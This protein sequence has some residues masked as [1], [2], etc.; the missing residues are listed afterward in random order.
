MLA[1]DPDV[2]S[3]LE[4]M[5]AH[6][7]AITDYPDSDGSAKLSTIDSR[8]TSILN[9]LQSID[10][11]PDSDGLIKLN[12]ILTTLQ[13]S[14]DYPDLTAHTKLDTINTSINTTSSTIDAT[15]NAIKTDIDTNVQ[16][17]QSLD[18][19]NTKT[20]T[21][22]NASPGSPWVGV[23]KQTRDLG[24]VRLLTT[25]VASDPSVSGTFTFEFSETGSE[26]PLGIAP[27]SAQRAISSFDSIRDFDLL[28]AGAYYRVAFEPDAH[29]GGNSVTITT[30]LRN[31]NDGAFARL[32]D[33]QIEEQN[34]AMG[35]TFAYLKAFGLD[36]LSETVRLGGLDPDNST[37]DN[38]ASDGTFV[39]QWR[40]TGPYQSALAFVLSDQPLAAADVAYSPD[41]VNDR[42]GLLSAIDFL[43]S[44]TVFPDILG[45]GGDL[46]VYLTVITTFV[47]RY[48]RL[49][50]TNSSTATTIFEAD[51][52]LYDQGFPGSFGGLNDDLST[53][54]TALLTRAVLAG[55]VLDQDGNVTDD[56]ANVTLT[57]N[58]SLKVA[59]PAEV[60][61]QATD[62]TNGAIPSGSLPVI[63]QVLNT[64]PNVIDTGWLPT[65]GYQGNNLLNVLADAQLTTYIMNASDSDGNNMFGDQTP[66]FTAN[67]GFPATLGAQFFDNYF[68]L[69]FVN[70]S[71]STLTD[72]SIRDVALPTPAAGVLAS[73]DS[74][75]FGFY[76][77]QI[78]RSVI[79]GKAP[80]GSYVNVGT[81]ESGRITVTSGSEFAR[82]L[83]R[84]VEDADELR[85][86]VEPSSTE[87]YI[88]SALDGTATS[89]TDWN[90]IQISLS[91]TRNPNRIRFRQNVAWDNRTAGW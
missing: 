49:E 1:N 20:I 45:P 8:L 16:L 64:E 52:W 80:S 54:S 82:L 5:L 83:A 51:L 63:D 55:N 14:N 31:Q 28:N 67:G 10:D 91:G 68:R 39:G 73:I 70:A 22:V 43:D 71:G 69:V 23:W 65:R 76:P 18:A 62:E 32:S 86:D 24:V 9:H 42:T 30:T 59:S 35:Q 4:D 38:L 34:A 81:D 13:S 36:G 75:V 37:Q 74:P 33:Q 89:A 17:H 47:D 48:I 15:L 84:Q 78:S 85:L 3:L 58:K 6:F 27:I 41:G 72:Y 2:E 26:G 60:V 25:L 79:V 53:L 77:A 21:S 61:F 12:D 40:N 87:F 50:L 66:S 88:G 11:Y 46:Y 7:Q 29:L 90:I 56:F 19:G 44:E 57:N